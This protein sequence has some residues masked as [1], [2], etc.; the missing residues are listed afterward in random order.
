[1]EASV[2]TKKILEVAARY[3]MR[4][5]AENIPKQQMDLKKKLSELSRDEMLAHAH[6]LLDGIEAYAK[7]RDGEGKCGR[8]LGF[9][10]AVLSFA[11]WYSLEELMDHNRPTK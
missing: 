8:H 3:R 7:A 9:M 2:D 10:Q 4:F 1:M 6:F 11:G 5:E